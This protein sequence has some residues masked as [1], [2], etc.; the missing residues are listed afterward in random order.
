[1]KR[2]GKARAGS[3]REW[4]IATG[5]QRGPGIPD[6]KQLDQLQVER[7][8]EFFFSIFSSTLVF[9]ESLQRVEFI[10]KKKINRPLFK[11]VTP[12]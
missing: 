6:R 1:M 12:D 11:R 9:S 10:G 7:T 4:A 5:D 8:D 2:A 3:G